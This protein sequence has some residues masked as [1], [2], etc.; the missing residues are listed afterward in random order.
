MKTDPFVGGFG[1]QQRGRVFETAGNKGRKNMR[2][3]LCAIVAAFTALPLF[4]QTN[5]ASAD[6]NA[7]PIGSTAYL[8]W[9]NGFNGIEFGR[10]LSS[11]KD[12]SRFFSNGSME[13]Y[14]KKDPLYEKVG[15]VEVSIQYIF[16][17]QKLV[18]LS[19][20]SR[21]K[22][23]GAKLL[24]AA[25][26]AYGKPDP[27]SG[28]YSWQWLGRTVRARFSSGADRGQLELLAVSF[29][30]SSISQSEKEAAESAK[31]F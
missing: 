4:A 2:I 24:E 7:P 21:D 3:I 1:D 29:I 20:F 30:Q 18:G 28:G 19:V 27:A 5:S 12:L 9:R 26:A 17:G 6:T 13:A 22:T 10:P 11:F 31:K 15:D 8:D 14:L 23:S 25:Q 16:S